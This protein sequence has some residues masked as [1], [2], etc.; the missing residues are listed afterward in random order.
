MNKII[1]T[2][3]LS[4][5]FAES[6]AVLI[7][8]TPETILIFKPEVH[9][10]GVRG[11]LIRYKKGGKEA[12]EKLTEEDFTKINLENL[13]KVEIELKTESVKKLVEAIKEREEIVKQGIKDGV[14]EYVVAEKDKVVVV[15][16]DTKRQVFEKILSKGYSDEFWSLMQESEPELANRLSIGYIQSEK[17]KVVLKFQTR[18]NEK[19]P[20]NSGSDSWQE[21]IYT[22]NWVFGL[23]YIKVIEKTKININGSIPDYIFLTADNFIDVLEIKLPE[24]DVIVEDPSHPGSYKWSSK[25]NEA[26]GQVVTYLGEIDRL[27]NELKREIKR[28]YKLDVSFVKPR[29]FIL[30]GK[31]DD[32]DD[33]NKEALRKLNF[34]LHGLEVLTYS[35][36]L[37]RSREIVNMFKE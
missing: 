5:N 24:E 3:T 16:N 27:Q 13:T 25:T 1:K 11:Y 31:K 15:D 33:F 19:H 34:A 28:I 36:L 10:G 2:K 12:W 14:Q 30:I 21:W 35:D 32:W 7:Y 26:V 4:R 9:E 8:K 29:G 17:Q 20:E 22:N 6:S 18:L 23:N 37:Q